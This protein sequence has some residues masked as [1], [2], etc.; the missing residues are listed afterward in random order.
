LRKALI[1]QEFLSVKI[2]LTK[3]IRVPVRGISRMKAPFALDQIKQ[4]GTG[5][6]PAFAVAILPKCPLCWMAIL[7]TF[8]LSSTIGVEWLR[9]MAALFL[10]IAVGALGLRARRIH[11]YGPRARRRLSLSIYSSSY[12]LSMPGFISRE[13]R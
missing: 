6:L 5:I 11:A 13:R 7:G 10:L 1:L 4:F 3:Q 12:S 2:H 8:G 9:P